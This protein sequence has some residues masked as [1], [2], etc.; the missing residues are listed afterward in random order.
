MKNKALLISIIAICVTATL[1]LAVTTYALWEKQSEDFIEVQIP[2][3]E[4]N[5]SAKYIVYKGV[6]ANGAFTED[7]ASIVSYAV[8]GYSG[9]VEELVIPAEYNGKAV[10]K[11]S[12][13]SDQTT[14]ALAGNQIVTSIVIPSS[15]TQIDQGVCVN[16]LRLKSVKILGTEGIVIQDLAFA[17]CVELTE[18]VCSREVTGTA[19]SYLAN[20][21]KG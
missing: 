19:S 8:V 11:I 3:D 13:S 21:P 2:T 18:F 20:T 5:P 1:A 16:M 4:F 6:D 10:T 17:G 15:V 7:E 14:V 9:I 12:S